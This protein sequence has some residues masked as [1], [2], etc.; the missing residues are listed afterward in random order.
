MNELEQLIKRLIE[1]GFLT[2]S[3]EKAVPL[4]FLDIE[5]HWHPRTRYI[6]YIDEFN[7]ITGKKYKPDIESRELYY[8]N[9]TIYSNIDRLT[10]L[11]NSLTDPWIKTNNTILTPKYA[12]KPENIAKYINYEA[13]KPDS[14]S[15][16][17][18]S[19]S[20]YDGP[21]TI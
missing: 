3:E 9:D 1:F 20:G 18:I 15:G 2:E 17:D 7:K 21:A 8:E 14:E 10:S 19:N 13:P 11:K 5:I 6:E 4:C 12:L 16:K